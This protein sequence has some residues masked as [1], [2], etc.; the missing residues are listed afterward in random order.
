MKCTVTICSKKKNDSPSLLPAY[1]RYNAPHIEIALQNAEKSGTPLYILSG[2]YGLISKDKLIPYYD[3]YLED[4]HVEELSK[5]IS[6][7]LKTEGITEIV[8]LGE[9]KAT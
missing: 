9:E 3:Y 5:I 6:G 4:S 2:K 1:K 8:F 7:Q